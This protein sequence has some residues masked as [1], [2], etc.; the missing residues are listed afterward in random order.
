[1]ALVPTLPRVTALVLVHESVRHLA[2]C[3]RALRA[4]D[5][6]EVEVVVID[7]GSSAPAREAVR[8]VVAA[9]GAGVS[10]LTLP[11]NLG[12]AGGNAVG[13]ARALD[14]GASW[15]L[16]VNDDVTVS[17]GAVARLAAGLAAAPGAAAA[18][19]T[20]RHA[21]APERIWWAGGTVDRVR[22]IGTHRTDATD[23]VGA[24]RDVG[25]LNGCAIFFRAEAL[26]VLGAFD[27][28]YFMYGEDVEWSL[29]AT[30]AGWRLLHVPEAVVAHDV[31]FPEPP[32]AAWKIHLRDRN[33]RRMVRTHFRAGERVWF[34]CWFYP[35]RLLRWA[36]YLA[37]GDGARAR[38]I[39]AGMQER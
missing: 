37:R 9:A 21:A 14:A 16:V 39:L 13:I 6:V 36:G 29:R 17:A 11:E 19:P 3:V 22:G 32:P 30:R 8:E 20:V 33:R 25:F 4:S 2:S 10:L 35:T 23:A 5:G 27:P 34:A 18:A 1:M 12:Y 31:P 38:A 7:N 15:V 26:R 24:P 28:S